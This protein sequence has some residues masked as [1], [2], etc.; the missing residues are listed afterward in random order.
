[1]PKFQS[2]TRI[3]LRFFA[4]LLGFGLLGYLVFRDRPGGRL[5]AS[6]GSRLGLSPDHHS[7]RVFSVDQDMR[8]AKDI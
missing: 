8:L 6:A 7:G 1:M 5:E 2:L 4:A 3:S